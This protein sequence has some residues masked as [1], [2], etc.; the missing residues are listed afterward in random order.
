MRLSNINQS[1]YIYI[2]IYISLWE[3]T[4]QLSNFWCSTKCSCLDSH[5]LWFYVWE[6]SPVS[7]YFKGDPIFQGILNWILQILL[8]YR[9]KQHKNIENVQLIEQKLSSFSACLSVYYDLCF[10]WLPQ[11][12][13]FFSSWTQYFVKF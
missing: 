6:N 12:Q 4:Y 10:L 7:N 5:I 8:Y 3:K 11:W 13:M 1:I 2:Y 9:S